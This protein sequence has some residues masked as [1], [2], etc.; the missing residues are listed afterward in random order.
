MINLEGDYFGDLIDLVIKK[1]QTIYPDLLVNQN[2][3]KSAI[4][5]EKIKFEKTLQAGLK[6]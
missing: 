1:Y 6:K 4:I 2:E 3:I 5:E